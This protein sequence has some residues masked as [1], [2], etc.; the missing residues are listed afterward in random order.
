LKGTSPF[1]PP[2]GKKDTSADDFIAGLKKQADAL[3]VSIREQNQGAESAKQLGLEFEFAAFKAKL[4][5]GS[6][7][8]PPDLERRFREAAGALQTLQTAFTM[9][10]REAEAFEQVAKR[11]SQDS[12]EWLTYAADVGKATEAVRRLREEW[13]KMRLKELGD[14]F[15]QDS[16]EIG[17][18]GEEA[19][20]AFASFKAEGFEKEWGNIEAIIRSGAD[21]IGTAF[22]GVTMGTQSIGEAFR[23]MGQ[24]IALSMIAAV[25]EVLILKP[26]LESLKSSLQEVGGLGGFFGSFFGGGFG[27]GAVP[28]LDLIPGFAKGGMV[29]GRIGAP[30]LVMAHGGETITPPNRG[31]GSKPHVTVTINGDIT[32]K[33]PN[34]TR[35]QVIQIGI[36]QFND[37]GAWT[38]TYENRRSRD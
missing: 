2:A 17:R 10:K 6:D 11:D 1:E 12:A 23:N 13:D 32:P 30:R 19:A 25:N 9:A 8:I 24:S 34:M 4:L 38:Q 28:D 3:R 14:A 16:E 31:G 18:M 33:Q 21:A 27:G 22:N 36:Q 37:R 5:A 20:R 35:D 29:P 26:A 15:D 7:P